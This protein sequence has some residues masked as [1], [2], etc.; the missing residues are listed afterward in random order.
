MYFLLLSLLASL[1]TATP[2]VKV[3]RRSNAIANKWIVKLKD[4]VA[5]MAVDGVKSALSTE[6]DYQYSMPGFRGFAGT[7]S[8]EE[9]ALLQVSDEI[10]YIQQDAEV[11]T[12]A[13]VKQLNATWGIS[14]IS[15]T[16]PRETTYLY[17]SSA[18]EGT[19]AYV[20]DTGVDITHPEF[21][22]RAFFLADLTHEGTFIDGFGHGT[23]VAGTIGSATWGIAKK[24]TIFAVRV[25][26]SNGWGTNSDVIAGLEFILRDARERKGTD[27]C[28]NGFVVNISLGS[29]KLPALNDAAAAMVAEDI[30]LGV[31]AGNDGVPADDFSPGSEPSVCT[32]GA[33]AAN[34]TLASWSNHGPRIDVLAPGLGITSTLPNGVVASFSGTSMAAPH[35][36]GLAAYLL[37]LGSPSKDLCGTI[38]ALAIKNAIDQ[39]TLPKGTPNL[40]AFNGANAS[41]KHTKHL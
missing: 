14:R 41:Q 12:T 20:I 18:G 8:D 13:L 30:F 28:R 27:Q 38:A 11:Y 19:C 4:N 2:L 35:V 6:P 32:V 21:Q 23:H 17:D 9:V 39:D 40:L 16:K 26:D 29:E 31:A 15:H 24:T 10:E 7:L 1:A 37:G 5:T 3:P 25:L 34:D 36:V 22:G 33:T